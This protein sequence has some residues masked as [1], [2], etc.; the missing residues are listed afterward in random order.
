MVIPLEQLS[1]R[2]NTLLSSC[3]A[4]HT[5]YSKMAAIMV[6]FCFPLNYPLQLLPRS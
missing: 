3:I 5:L 6:L 2:L 1:P 4:H